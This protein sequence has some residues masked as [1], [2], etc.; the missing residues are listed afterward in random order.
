[1][2]TTIYATASTYYGRY[3]PS[4]TMQVGTAVE[5]DLALLR[6]RTGAVDGVVRPRHRA[7]DSR[8][9]GATPEH[10]SDHHGGCRR[11]VPLRERP[12]GFGRRRLPLRVRATAADYW[13]RR[14]PVEVRAD[15]R[16]TPRS[17]HAARV[18]TRERVRPGH[19]RRGR[20]NPSTPWRSPDRSHHVPPDRT[21]VSAS[22]TSACRRR[23][24]RGSSRSRRPSRATSP[25]PSRSTCSAAQ[26]CRSCTDQRR[27]TPARSLERS[28]TQRP[29]LRSSACSSVRTGAGRRPPTRTAAT[30]STK[31][32]RTGRRTPTTGR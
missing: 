27:T 1:M 6:V 17:R 4:T 10:W 3:S 20:A 32:P 12:A 15:P 7:P 26:R 18:R 2:S 11:K 16:R 8:S 22:P 30:R 23:T 9:A 14:M 24:L 21:G 25:S 5:V 31:H 19:R 28:P 29:D 13:A